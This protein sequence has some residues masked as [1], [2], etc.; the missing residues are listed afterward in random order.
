MTIS[1]HESNI[2]EVGPDNP[3]FILNDG[4]AISYRASIR[5]SED[6]PHRYRNLIQDA[7]A[8]GWII[9]VARMY[10]HE[11]TFDILKK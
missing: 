2:V 3:L 8:A 6:C 7:L 11:V 1:F 9:P 5:L 10:D 4:I